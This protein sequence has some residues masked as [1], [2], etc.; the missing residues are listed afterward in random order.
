MH[1]LNVDVIFNPL[2]P[3]DWTQKAFHYIFGRKCGPLF[4]SLL[5]FI[6]FLSV[7]GV[8]VGVTVYLFDIRVDLKNYEVFSKIGI[9]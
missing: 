3:K 1:L 7:V 5:R 9:K 2:V 8:S 4:H 6:I